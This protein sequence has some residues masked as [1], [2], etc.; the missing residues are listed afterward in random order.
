[1]FRACKQ[2]KVPVDEGIGAD[3]SAKLNA[4]STRPSWS[5]GRDRSFTHT[6]ALGRACSRAILAGSSP[7][8]FQTKVS[9]KI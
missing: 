4:C 9:S 8:A 6:T 5:G 1:M 2:Q 7:A 3:R